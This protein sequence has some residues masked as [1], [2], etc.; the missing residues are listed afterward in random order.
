MKK[1]L[2]FIILSLIFVL[3]GAAADDCLPGIKAR[4]AE[5][6]KYQKTKATVL[7]IAEDIIIGLKN[8]GF[9]EVEIKPFETLYNR[10][11]TQITKLEKEKKGFPTAWYSNKFLIMIS[12]LESKNKPGNIET[13]TD[14]Q[15][16]QE[17]GK[18][19]TSA[20]STTITS[21]LNSSMKPGDADKKESK[22]AGSEK[23]DSS[24]PATENETP[25]ASSFMSEGF[26]SDRIAKSAENLS[27]ITVAELKTK[28]DVVE[29]K[30]NYLS[31]TLHFYQIGFIV[32]IICAFLGLGLMALFIIYWRKDYKEF[33][34]ARTQAFRTGPRKD[35][36]TE[37]E[38]VSSQRFLKDR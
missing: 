34:H 4:A 20:T 6:K 9:S 15:N 8:C 35:A 2:I 19:G 17:T 16:P 18:A 10:F 22:K 11:E 33:L 27:V 28:L 3:W 32:L 23:K 30:L 5:L 29:K 13:P 12:N 14:T 7:K 36:W 1:N 31:D 21:S 38:G 25:D 37:G 24:L 26:V